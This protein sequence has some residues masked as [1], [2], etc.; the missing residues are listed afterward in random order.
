MN[1]NRVAKLIEET[2]QSIRHI[3]NDPMCPSD[4]AA[5][6]AEDYRKD[7]NQSIRRLEDKTPEEQETANDYLGLMALNEF[8]KRVYRG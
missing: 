7:L 3:Y 5:E 8:E 2:E 6:F 4:I 1:N